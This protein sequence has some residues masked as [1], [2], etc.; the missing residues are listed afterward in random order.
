MIIIQGP[1]SICYLSLAFNLVEL[2][3]K[4]KMEMKGNCGKKC[5]NFRQFLTV[6]RSNR[7]GRLFLWATTSHA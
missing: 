3:L 1:P 6:P 4:S 7:D 2:K 5:Q